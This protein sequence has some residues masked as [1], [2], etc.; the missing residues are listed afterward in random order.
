MS[1]KVSIDCQKNDQVDYRCGGPLYLGFDFYIKDKELISFIVDKLEKYNCPILKMVRS[2]SDVPA[3][4]TKKLIEKEIK[5]YA[6]TEG[7]YK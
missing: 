1:I 7:W 6:K 4:W 2:D 3:E 5:D